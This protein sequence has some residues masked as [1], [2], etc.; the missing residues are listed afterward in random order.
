ML[1]DITETRTEH[2]IKTAR[3]A[4]LD[5]ALILDTETSGLDDRSQLVQIAVIDCAGRLEYQTLV[6]PTIPIPADATKI[7]GITNEHVK[8]APRWPDIAPEVIGLI[9]RRNV[10]A[11]NS[12]YDSR[13]LK[14]TS[15]AHGYDHPMFFWSC[16]MNMYMDFMGRNRWDRLEKACGEI[17]YQFEG[18]QHTA[19]CDAKAARAVLLWLAKQEY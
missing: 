17:G 8:D 14:Q 13:V 7:H 2:I 4:V 19:L 9:G 11:Y 6:R 1:K 16:I 12:A 3:K 5:N 15:D 18:Q 10:L